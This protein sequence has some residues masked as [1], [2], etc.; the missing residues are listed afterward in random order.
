MNYLKRTFC[1]FLS[2]DLLLFSCSNH[3][4]TTT[5]GKDSKD[6]NQT[7]SGSSIKVGGL[8][9]TSGKDSS[10][11][12]CKIIA[13]DEFAVHIRYYENKFAHPP[14]QISSDTLKVLIGHAPLDKNGFLADNPQLIKVEDVKEEELEG[15]KIYLQQTQ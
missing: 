6:T 14:T 15:Y 5:T 8:Y 2:A 4:T 11:S 7:S 13:M 3:D 10:Y 1:I 9:S 12:V